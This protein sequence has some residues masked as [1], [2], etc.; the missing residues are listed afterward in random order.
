MSPHMPSGTGYPQAPERDS[1]DVASLY[2][3]SGEDTENAYVRLQ[4]ALTDNAGRA[5]SL[6]RGTYRFDTGLAIPANTVLR[7]APGAILQCRVTGGGPGITLANAA[8]LYSDGH[9]AD[10]GQV[11]AYATCNVSS[12]ITN[13]N[14]AGGQEFA[15][16]E[17]LYVLAHSGAVIGTALVDMV[18]L[19]VNSAV[20]HCVI[21]CND[22]APTG[23][24]IAGGTT[25]GGNGPVVAEDV[26]VNHATGH[27]IV[28]TENNPP[29]GFNSVWMADITSENPGDNH[30]GLFIQG[31]G[32]MNVKLRNYHYENGGTVS[33]MSAAVYAD[34]APGLEIDGVEVLSDPIANKKGVVLDDCYRA[35]VWNV[36]NPNLVNPILE[37]VQHGV[38]HG[39]VNV[40]FYESANAGAGSPVQ[41]FRHRVTF[42]DGVTVKTKAG[43]IADGDFDSTPPDGTI[44]VD[45]ANS[46][47]YVRVGGAWVSVAVS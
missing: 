21:A 24:R 11:H 4:E 43:A 45:T 19:F 18:A 30:H 3:L 25:G 14:H 31:F 39:A 34:F 44:A 26:W 27:N 10:T 41:Q 42:T 9:G 23:L 40:S 38:S 17:G 33:T 1:I 5:L 15:F 6:R 22:T 7:V 47:L 8:K 35:K 13:V 46:E 2:G 16:I 28:V 12:L 37:D 36:V 32:N 20:R 29:S